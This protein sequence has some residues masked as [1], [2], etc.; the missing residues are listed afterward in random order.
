MMGDF[1]AFYLKKGPEEYAELVRNLRRSLGSDELLITGFRARAYMPR[2][3][4]G[5]NEMAV[6]ARKYRQLTQGRLM[7]REMNHGVLRRIQG[8]DAA[9]LPADPYELTPAALAAVRAR[10]ANQPRPSTS[11]PE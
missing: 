9:F 2:P 11:S 7:G 4:T 10:L 6:A 5:T 8:G 1:G 3:D